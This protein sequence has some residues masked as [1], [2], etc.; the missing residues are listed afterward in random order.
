MNSV[1]SLSLWCRVTCH[2]RNPGLELLDTLGTL[3]I[4]ICSWQQEAVLL[5]N[6][7]KSSVVCREPKVNYHVLTVNLSNSA[8]FVEVQ[9]GTW[10]HLSEL[11]TKLSSPWCMRFQ[12]VD[13][14]H[15]HERSTMAQ[16][17]WHLTPVP[18]IHSYDGHLPSNLNQCGYIRSTLGGCLQAGFQQAVCCHQEIF[19][20]H[21]HHPPAVSQYHLAGQC[22]APGCHSDISSLPCHCM[23]HFKSTVML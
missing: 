16:R 7:F 17:V 14:C 11:F 13:Y 15:L 9:P 8:F 6:I 18:H 5:C 10:H 1:F 20:L 4:A 2:S 22:Q 23:C 19:Q 12:T 3:T 21:S